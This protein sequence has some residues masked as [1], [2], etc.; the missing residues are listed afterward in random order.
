MIHCHQAQ[1]SLL[2]LVPVMYRNH[3]LKGQTLDIITEDFMTLLRQAMANFEGAAESLTQ[4]TSGDK[5]AQLDAAAFVEWC[6][7][8]ITGVLY[9]SLESP[10]YGM[11]QCVTEDGYVNL[12]L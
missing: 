5:Q 8:F 4:L 6:R 2:N 12:I 3:G 11:A 10:R 1:G 9:W 7:Y